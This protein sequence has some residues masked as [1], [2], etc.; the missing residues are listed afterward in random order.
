MY[1]SLSIYTWIHPMREH[2]LYTQS[3]EALLCIRERSNER[4]HSNERTRSTHQSNEALL[5]IN[6]F[7]KDLNDTNQLIRSSALR[8][9]TR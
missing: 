1:I 5:C 2:V 7:Q 8:V 6:T 3:N 9:L 4:T